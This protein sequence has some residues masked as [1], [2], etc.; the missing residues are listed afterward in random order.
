MERGVFWACTQCGGRALSVELLRVTFTNES[1]NPLWLRTIR[2]QG[3]TGRDC[4]GCRHPM[5]E[6]PLA[7]DPE[8]PAV[9]VCRRCHFVWFDASE[10]S[11]LKPREIPEQEPSLS[12]EAREA[13]APQRAKTRVRGQWPHARWRADRRVVATV[14][15]LSLDL[16]A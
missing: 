9:D 6:V 11:G 7:E 15:S 5:I 3:R 12:L 1:I 8:A 2:G 13:R 4:A 14:C 16:V 10:I